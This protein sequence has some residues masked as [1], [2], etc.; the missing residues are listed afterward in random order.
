Y[1]KNNLP[2]TREGILLSLVNDM[3]KNAASV[4]S[5]IAL[6]K[7]ACQWI[8]DNAADAI[9]AQDVANALGL[10]REHLGRVIKAVGGE[11]L[12]K[13]TAEF[14]IIEIKRLCAD[15]NLT[16]SDIAGELSFGSAELLCKFFKYH[17]GISVTE[18]RNNKFE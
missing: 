1:F 7:K 5:E 8:E 9:S 13:K 12:C 10:S 11:S 15:K 18:Y 2:G 4:S 17:T 3:K 16:L 14:R 6:Y